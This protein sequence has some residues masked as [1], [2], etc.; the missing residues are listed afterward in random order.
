MVTKYTDTQK[1]YKY[2]QGSGL[3]AG[4]NTFM[5]TTVTLFAAITLPIS[6]V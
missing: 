4:E 5:K 3:T 1:N 2:T 6:Y